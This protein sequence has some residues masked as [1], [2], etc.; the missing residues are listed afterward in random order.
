MSAQTSLLRALEGLCDAAEDHDTHEHLDGPDCVPAVRVD[1]IRRLI[2]DRS[3][4][5]HGTPIPAEAELPSG[6][7]RV[8][9]L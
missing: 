3:P 6:D 9:A 8:E 2:E 1:A 4:L 5:G 7:A